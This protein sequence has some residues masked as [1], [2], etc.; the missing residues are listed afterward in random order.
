MFVDVLTDN[1]NRTGAEIRSVFS[2]A[3]G[4]LP[5]LEQLLGSLSV[6]A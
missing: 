3:G 1:R 2:R 4:S 6:R 5:N